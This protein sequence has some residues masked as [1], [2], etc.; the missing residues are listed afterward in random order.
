MSMNNCSK[1]WRTLL[2]DPLGSA[3]ITADG[4]EGPGRA[5]GAIDLRLGGD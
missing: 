4:K 3:L 5:P 2:E 1:S